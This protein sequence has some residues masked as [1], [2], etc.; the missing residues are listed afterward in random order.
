MITFTKPIKSFNFVFSCIVFI[1]LF[2][3]I[4]VHSDTSKNIENN[5]Q[6]TN[7]LWSSYDGCFQG[8]KESV[9]E[10]VIIA[11]R[12]KGDSYN[13][14]GCVQYG[15]R[16]TVPEFGRK[17]YQVNFKYDPK[18]VWLSDTVFETVVYGKNTRFYQC[19]IK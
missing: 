10:A 2:A 13:V 19:H 17:T 16:L 18:F 1:A 9:N 6:R 11:I 4:S 3:P 7:T 15:C 14:T 12:T 8:D 5:N